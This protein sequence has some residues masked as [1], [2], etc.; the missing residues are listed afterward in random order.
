M[1][2]MRTFAVLLIVAAILGGAGYLLLA[3]GDPA[4]REMRR[5]QFRQAAVPGDT[6]IQA[7]K[8]FAQVAGQP[9]AT[10]D[11]IVPTHL[12]RLPATGVADCPEFEYRVLAN[13]PVA[14]EW[15]D[16]GSRDGRAFAGTSHYRDGDP[17]HAILVFTL[18]AENKVGSALI[19]RLP[20]DLETVAFDSARWKARQERLE[21]AP[22][23]AETY[24]LYGMPRAVF[25]QLLGPPDG[26]RTLQQAPWELRIHCPRGLFRRDLLIYWPT[27]HYPAQLYG[28]KTELIGEWVYVHD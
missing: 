2:C 25:E 1:R 8:A 12:R 17:G 24:R 9:P 11:G 6:L 15:Y 13:L 7:I 18:D 28:G 4:E 16:L 26:R 3:P 10:L 5:L 27:G 20:K 14:I 22:E 19:D 23:L 21:M